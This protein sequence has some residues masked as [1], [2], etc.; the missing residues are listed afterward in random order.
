MTEP[1]SELVEFA[2]IQTDWARRFAQALLRAGVRDLVISPGSRSTPLVLALTENK[3]LRC[4]AISDERSAGFFAV[5][6]SKISGRPTALLCTSGSAPGH[7][8]PA[9]MEASHG[10]TPLLVISANRPLER[11]NCG[12]PQTTDQRRLFGVHSRGFF[13]TGLAEDGARSHRALARTVDQAV[14]LTQWPEAGPVQIDVRLRKPLEPPARHV[15]T[16]DAQPHDVM[17]R[18]FPP[19]VTMSAH[20][21][22]TLAE[23]LSRA[24]R[25]LIVAG[26]ACLSA[27]RWRSPIQALCQAGIP[28]ALEVTS[29]LSGCTEFRALSTWMQ[30]PRFRRIVRPDFVLQIGASPVSGGWEPWIESLVDASRSRDR[31]VK[32][33]V[34]AEAGD[35]DPVSTVTAMLIGD[36]SVGLTELASELC[37]NSA[38]R[39]WNAWLAKL[40]RLGQKAIRAAAEG[41]VSEAGVA[42][43]VTET[44]PKGGL[45]A[46][47]NSLAVRL[48]DTYCAGPVAMGGSLVWHQ[49]GLNGI[50]GIPSGV[51]GSLDALAK[52]RKGADQAP[53]ETPIAAHLLIGDVSLVHDLGGLSLLRSEA[54]AGLSVVVIDNGGGRIFDRLPVGRLALSETQTGFFS[55]PPMVE[56]EKAAQTFGLGFEVVRDRSH[57]RDLLTNNKARERARLLQVKAVPGQEAQAHRALLADLSALLPEELTG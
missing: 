50:D 57:L 55:T 21:L 10:R 44:L 46:L 40:D 11:E 23:R 53:S 20:G 7:Y 8:Y 2:R 43:V 47:G 28:A 56:L 39:A 6:Q 30:V 54:C 17:P 14:C 32:H 18:V 22:E 52:G 35:P 16:D 1:G 12:A 26:P 15:V 41:P 45:M 33:W 9:V 34:M 31:A 37:E 27:R 4:L 36:L 49:R 42:E 38:W 25:P 48:A 19:Q 5:G 13:E 24:Q 3:K 51:A 29:Q